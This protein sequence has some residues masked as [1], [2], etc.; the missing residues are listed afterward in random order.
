MRNKLILFFV[1]SVLFLSFVGAYEYEFNGAFS[2][3][4]LDD[5]EVRYVEVVEEGFELPDVYDK[6]GSSDFSVQYVRPADNYFLDAPWKVD[7]DGNIILLAGGI[8]VDAELAGIYFLDANDGDAVIGY[9]DLD[10]MVIS[11]SAPWFLFFYADKSLLKETDGKF[12]VKVVYD[13]FWSYYT[14]G[15][16]YVEADVG[17]MP[18]IEDWY[19][20]DT[21]YHSWYTSTNWLGGLAGEVGAPISFTSKIAKEVMDFDWFSVTDHSNSF[22]LNKDSAWNWSRFERDCGFYSNCL[23]GEEVNCRTPESGNWMGNSLPGN[24]FLAYDIDEVF[25]D[26]GQ[27]DVPFCDEIVESVNGQGGFGYVAHP[28]AMI[29]IVVADILMKWYDYS[30]PFAGLEIWNGDIEDE[31]VAEDLE[32]GIEKWKDVLLGRAGLEARRVYVS[33]GSDAHGDFQK[34]GREY[35]CCYAEEYSK[36]NIF[37]ALEAGTCYMGNNGALA[38]EIDNL[39]GEVAKMGEEIDVLAGGDVQF[40]IDSFVEEDCDFYFVEGVVGGEETRILAGGTK[41][42]YGHLNDVFS[43]SDIGLSVESRGYYRLECVSSDGMNRI[44][45]NPIWVNPVECFVDGDCEESSCKDSVCV[46]GKLCNVVSPTDGDVFTN[47][48]VPFDVV[49]VGDLSLIEYIDYSASSPRWI[50]LC[51]NCD[52]YTG[53]RIFSDGEHEVSVR[54]SDSFESEEHG[55]DFFVDSV[56]PVILGV[57]PRSGFSD[58]SFSLKFRE[59]NPSGVFLHYGNSVE[60]VDGCVKGGLNWECDVSSGVSDGEVE[61]WFVVEDVAGRSVESAVNKVIVDSVAPVVT[62]ADSFWERGSGWFSSYVYFDISVD[63]ENFKEVA[64]DYDYF[65]RERSVRLCGVLNNGACKKRVRVP[66][67]YENVG[68]VVR[69]LAE[70]WAEYEL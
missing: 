34:F 70:N 43:L 65:G 30:L 24:H 14:E 23:I 20:G 47:G 38:F 68:I 25:L 69:D 36:A 51:R 62:N 16:V 15:P 50:R 45:T 56:A 32:N 55:F 66:S 67:S 2:S 49:G 19:C 41:H 53:N 63:E 64:L 29:D 13:D 54:C 31:D 18:K 35:T 46:S 28:E 8:G 40:N 21:H 33:A 39:N 3:E 61:F 12:A 11:S 27:I 48:V 44:Y 58:G 5:L 26:N 42:S 37:G 17:E 60:T 1:F 57:G 22:N 4:G 6:E 59:D 52:G 7:E 9:Y 10:G